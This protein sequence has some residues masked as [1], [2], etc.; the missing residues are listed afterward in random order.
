MKKNYI[1]LSVICLLT[2]LI[3]CE[4]NAV[5]TIDQPITDGA[6]IRFFNFAANAPSVNFYAN[7]AKLSAVLSATGAENPLG[8][9][10]TIA[11]PASNYLLID[12][13]SYDFKGQI[14][15]TAVADANLAVSTLSAQ[16]EAN[17]A[18]SF[19]MSGVYNATAKAADAF[20]IE[21]VLP[22][23][24]TTGT[25]VRFVNAISNAA[26]AFNLVAK[27]TS[28]TSETIV[29]T[30]IAYKSGSEFIKLQPGVYELYA[31][32][33]ESV[34]NIISRAGT[35]T[36]SFLPGRIYTVT[37]RGDAT[38]TSGVAAPAFDNTANK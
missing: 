1:L 36:V 26:G 15:S 25:Y 27:N 2:I 37:S 14:S 12:Q 11:Y 18:Y 24:D 20:I 33:P 32:Y 19:Y 9:A 29:A 28:T 13:G 16:V 31:R 30:N 22:Q 10:Y 5:Q 34:V 23:T 21:D 17:K 38:L 6:Q 8:T 4:K 7:E 3:S 35:Q